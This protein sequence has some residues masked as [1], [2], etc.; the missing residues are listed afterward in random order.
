[1]VEER[2]T[3]DELTAESAASK[4]N[5]LDLAEEVDKVIKTQLELMELK[6]FVSRLESR[7]SQL[8]RKTP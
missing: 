4:R 1:M 7:V 6:A 2:K 5:I 3:L 8:E